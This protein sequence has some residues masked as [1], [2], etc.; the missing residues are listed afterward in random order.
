MSK[1]RA[2]HWKHGP[3][4]V[5]AVGHQGGRLVGALQLCDTPTATSS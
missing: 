1:G 2:L 3:D 5:F 4:E